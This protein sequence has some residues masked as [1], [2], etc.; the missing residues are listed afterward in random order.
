MQCAWSGEGEIVGRTQD[1]HAPPRVEDE[2]VVIAA[3]DDLCTGRQSKLQIFVVLWVTAVGDA[4]SGTLL[5]LWGAAPCVMI[6][7][8]NE[9]A[10]DDDAG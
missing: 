2:K 7:S 6:R 3:D 8:S 9:G 10:E 1:E 5:T 4:R